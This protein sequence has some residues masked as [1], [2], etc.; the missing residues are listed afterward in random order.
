MTLLKRE[1]S[2]DCHN[3]GIKHVRKKIITHEYKNGCPNVTTHL[4]RT[5]LKSFLSKNS[6]ITNINI[7][8]ALLNPGNIGKP[9]TIQNTKK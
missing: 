1:K 5:L 6:V 2:C 8:F 7:A 3:I 9:N 4:Y